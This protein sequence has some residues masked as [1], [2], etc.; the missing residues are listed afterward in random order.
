MPV[1]QE[2]GPS[3]PELQCSQSPI[4]LKRCYT[5]FKI[6]CPTCLYMHGYFWM[7]SVV[8]IY[9][10]GYP[11]QERNRVTMHWKTPWVCVS[12]L[13]FGLYPHTDV[14]QVLRYST[15]RAHAN[16]DFTKL[17]TWKI[18]KTPCTG[19]ND[20]MGS[21]MEKICDLSKDCKGRIYFLL[22]FK[23]RFTVYL[24]IAFTHYWHYLLNAASLT[25]LTI[26]CH[27][28][29]FVKAKYQIPVLFWQGCCAIIF[30]CNGQSNAL[31]AG[32]R[33]QTGPATFLD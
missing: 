32:P 28:G 20:P 3:V 21:S 22:V 8:N 14:H 11:D 24:V 16:S 29:C 30:R 6:L 31:K 25:Y 13:R 18:K 19:E 23:I 15:L 9:A 2:L 5:V 17:E 27:S 10:H 4:L 1:S 7:T 33:K 12:V 26:Y